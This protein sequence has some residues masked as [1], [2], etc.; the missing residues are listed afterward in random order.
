MVRVGPYNPF[1]GGVTCSSGIPPQRVHDLDVD[2]ESTTALQSPPITP[3]FQQFPL[4]TG[5]EETVQAV[6]SAERMIDAHRYA[7]ALT[8]LGD[9]RVPT[10][11]APELALRVLLADGWAR[12][13]IGETAA[14]EAILERARGLSEAPAIGEMILTVGGADT[15]I[16]EASDATTLFLSSKARA[17]TRYVPMT[18]GRQAKV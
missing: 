13:N 8:V 6:E 15:V 11:S 7:D 10:M 14:A 2:M 1:R 12:L 4:P 17:V 3:A 18:V 5:R 9:V 16:T